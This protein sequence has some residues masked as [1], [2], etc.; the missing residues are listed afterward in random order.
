[1]AQIKAQ[2]KEDQPQYLIELLIPQWVDHMEALKVFLMAKRIL[3]NQIIILSNLNLYVSK[4]LVKNR[5]WLIICNLTDI[6][7]V[8]I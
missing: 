2:V 3:I 8:I 7:K 4:I 5:W 1:M 6:K